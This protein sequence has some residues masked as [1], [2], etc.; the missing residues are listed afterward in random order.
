V[1]AFVASSY[2]GIARG[3][4]GPLRGESP[5]SLTIVNRTESHARSLAERFAPNGPVSACAYGDLAGHAFDIVID[6][7]S[8]SLSDTMPALPAGI[9]APGSLAY[10][11]MYGLTHAPFSR[12]AREQGAETVSDGIGMLLEQ[13]AEAFFVWRGVRPDCAPVAELLRNKE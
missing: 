5:E 4:V 13:A 10:M 6:A 1:G 7:T 8:T 12:F 11:L 2:F 3:A 9:F